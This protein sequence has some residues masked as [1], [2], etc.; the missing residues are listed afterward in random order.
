MA[1]ARQ[2]RTIE[3]DGAQVILLQDLSRYTL[4]LRKAVK[5]LLEKEIPYRWG[6]PFQ[7]KV[8]HEGQKVIFRDITD[9]PDFLH[10]LQLPKFDLLQWPQSY[11]DFSGRT[12]R[13]R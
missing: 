10:N 7:I 9:L 3:I 1:A 12:S 4:F 2:Q 6:F 8:Y 11:Q 5:P 13:R